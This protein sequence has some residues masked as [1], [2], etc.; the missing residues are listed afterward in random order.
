MV[1]Y[2]PHRGGLAEA[3]SESKE[4][5]SLKD[6]VDYIVDNFNSTVDCFHIEATDLHIAKYSD[7]DERIGW[8]DV[9][10]V[11][12]LPYNCIHDKHGYKKYFNH[13]LYHMPTGVLGFFTTDYE[14]SGDTK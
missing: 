7:N 9:F 11:C 1:M 6:M 12:F 4:F 3:M 5:K 2:R 14:K 13:T 10:V 8:H